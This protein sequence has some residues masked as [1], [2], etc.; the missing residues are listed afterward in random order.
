[1]RIYVDLVTLLPTA[2]LWQRAEIIQNATAKRGDGSPL[3]IQFHRS[4]VPERLPLG[5]VVT[6]IAK[7][8]G[9]FDEN[10]ALVEIELTDANRPESDTGFYT[11]DPDYNTEPLDEA[12]ASGDDDDE[13]D[14]RALRTDAEISWLAGTP[15]AKPKSSQTFLLL[16]QNDVKKGNEGPA[17]SGA[18]TYLT[19]A[20]SDARYLH[21]QIASVELVED[22]DFIDFDISAAELEDLP[23]IVAGLGVEKP[24]AEADNIWITGVF[25]VD[26]STIRAWLSASPDSAGYTAHVLFR[27]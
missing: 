9:K 24:T 12:L 21:A 27:P 6:F 14:V 10:P 13:N 17:A 4:G 8:E 11:A 23:A 25:A 16:I 1:M 26:A 5:Y 3:E 15:G 20:Q 22:Q 7:T 18:P 19:A 2:E